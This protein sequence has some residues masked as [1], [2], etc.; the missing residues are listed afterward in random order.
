MYIDTHIY[1]YIS[2][3]EEKYLHI[4]VYIY[5]YIYIYTYIYEIFYL[6]FE[7]LITILK[8]CPISIIPQLALL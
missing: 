4:Y 5:I 1:I 6:A 8:E 7:K 3:L 2:S